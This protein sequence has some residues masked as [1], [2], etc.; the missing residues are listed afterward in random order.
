MAKSSEDKWVS[1]LD[2]VARPMCVYQCSAC[3]TRVA[4]RDGIPQRCPLGSCQKRGTM[5]TI[6]API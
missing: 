1:N 5:E 6:Y 2:P 3:A 4:G